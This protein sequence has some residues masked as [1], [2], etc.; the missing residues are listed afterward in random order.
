MV[1]YLS[2]RRELNVSL[3]ITYLIF[4]ISL[5]AAAVDLSVAL[6]TWLGSRQYNLIVSAVMLSAFA[7]FIFYFVK[8][9]NAVRQAADIPLLYMLIITGLTAV[10]V[11]MNFV[12]NIEIIH[13]M[14]FG[15]IALLIF[16]LTRS[17]GA[18][19]YY[20]LLLGIVDEWYQH[21]ILYPDKSDYFDFNDVVLDQLGAGITLVY[22]YSAGAKINPVAKKWYK[23]PVLLSAAGI[24]AAVAALF[25]FSVMTVYSPSAGSSWFVLNE[26]SGPEAFWRHVPN[27]EIVYHVMTPL[28]GVAAI[29]F[30]C[31]MFYLLD[32]LARRYEEGLQGAAIGPAGA[33]ASGNGVPDSISVSPVL[34]VS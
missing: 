16:P 30:I 3:L 18:T 28:E 1:L 27:S 32:F 11:H 4:I 33:A 9:L 24:A 17:F 2:S 22:L 26:A 34:P 7:V 29:V 13:T 8:N 31:G 6:M 20:T 14:Q 21:A 25:H 23:S 10:H 12:M 15:I 5:H 19:L